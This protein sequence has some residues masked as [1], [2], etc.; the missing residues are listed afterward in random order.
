M[1]KCCDNFYCGNKFL[2]IFFF[3]RT[4]A[5][6][7]RLYMFS[8]TAANGPLAAL[9][10]MAQAREE[11]REPPSIIYCDSQ[12]RTRPDSPTLLWLTGRRPFPPAR[13]V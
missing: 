6:N 10:I 9:S 13:F 7:G 12:S 11:Q 1:E 4:E 2:E 3:A 5:F 8:A